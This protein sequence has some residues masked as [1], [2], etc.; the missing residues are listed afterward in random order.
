MCIKIWFRY[1]QED[2]VITFV[3]QMDKIVLLLPEYGFKW[4]GVS[5]S[6]RNGDYTIFCCDECGDEAHTSFNPFIK[7]YCVTWHTYDEKPHPVHCSAYL[8]GHRIKV[9]A[10]G[11]G[12]I[13]KWNDIV[14]PMLKKQGYELHDSK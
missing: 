3:D 13:N 8:W 9:H 14:M 11:K 1:Y 7:D 6:S 4:Q 12:S 2:P 5:G 10:T